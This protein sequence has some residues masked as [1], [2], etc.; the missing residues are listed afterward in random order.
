MLLAQKLTFVLLMPPAGLAPPAGTPSC[1]PAPD[2]PAYSH[3]DYANPRP[4]FNALEL[5]YRGV[6]VD[7][8]LMGDQ[9]V[10]A[11]E[12]RSAQR[13]R[14]L[15]ALYLRPLSLLLNRCG[16]KFGRRQPFLLT[17]ELKE[18]SRAA[19]NHLLGI[20]KKYRTLFEAQDRPRAAVEVVLVGWHPPIRELADELPSYI[21]LQQHVTGRRDEVQSD[22]DGLVRLVSLNYGKTI[23]W[24]GAGP[25]PNSLGE[26]LGA[27]QRARSSG[28][29]RLI[30]VFNAPVDTAVYQRL[31][32][33][34]VDLVGIKDLERGRQT[35]LKLT[36]QTGRRSS[37]DLEDVN[38]PA[39]ES[40]ALLLRESDGAITVVHDRHVRRRQ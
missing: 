4:L 34:S 31:L 17:L 8:V 29:D 33:G 16:P 37:R 40:P 12:R 28:P 14:T 15:E 27:L 9:L 25:P 39:G 38:D 36:G 21:R 6:E 10:A 35:L 13:G 19:Y 3:N 32:Q 11:H 1:P 26:W 23:R 5:G 24:S 2:L 20:L 18:P 22:Q 30:R 7:V